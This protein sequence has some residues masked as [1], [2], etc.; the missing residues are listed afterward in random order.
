MNGGWEF[1]EDGITLLDAAMI[2]VT[3]YRWRA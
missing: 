2:P 1:T 3:R